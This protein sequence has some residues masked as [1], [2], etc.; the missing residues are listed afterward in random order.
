MNDTDIESRQSGS[1]SV[2]DPR[3]PLRWSAGSWKSSPISFHTGSD[4]LPG[5]LIL[6]T[7]AANNKPLCHPGGGTPPASF[8]S[9]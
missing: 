7:L 4:I 6:A 3:L 5:A 1:E 2:P 8:L 9:F